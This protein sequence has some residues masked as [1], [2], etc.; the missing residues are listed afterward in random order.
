MSEQGLSLAQAIISNMEQV[1]ANRA[2]Y[3]RD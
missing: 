3:A 2:A 1:C